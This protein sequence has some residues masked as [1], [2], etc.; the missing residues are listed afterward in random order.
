MHILAMVFSLVAIYCAWL[1]SRDRAII[2]AAT[3]E[4]SK[5]RLSN[6]TYWHKRAL[7][8]SLLGLAVALA[9]LILS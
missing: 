1:N 7:I 4:A 5:A 8:L 9:S 2:R 6:I 3:D